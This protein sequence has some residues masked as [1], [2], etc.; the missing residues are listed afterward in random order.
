MKT[1]LIIGG[2][3]AGCAAGHIL[4]LQG[5]WNIDLVERNSFL[6]AGVHTF[7]RG[8]H[9]YTFGPRH[10]LTQNEETYHYLNKYCPLRDCSEHILLTYIEQDMAFYNFPMHKDD[11]L[12]MPDRDIIYREL[13]KAELSKKKISF[14]PSGTVTA[15]GGQFFATNLE[16]FWISS[17]GPT[18][19]GKFVDEYN[20]KMW[21]VED[22]KS[23][24]DFGWSPKGVALKEGPKE[25]WDDCISAYPIAPDGYN[26]YFEIATEN[27]NVIL[28]TTI[29][30]YDI[31][32]KTVVINSEKKVYDVIIN[33]IS[34][35]EIMDS[36]H[37]ELLFIGRDLEYFVLPVKET[38]PEN[39]YFLYYAGEE[40]YTRIVEYKKLTRQN[41]D[42]PTTLLSIEYPSKNGK[43]YPVPIKTE[44]AK[45]K[46]YF[47][48]MPGGVF[49]I[50]RAGSYDY[51][52]DIDDCIEQVLEIGKLLKS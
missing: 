52:I 41:L 22:N 20:K 46:K 10:F 42:H 30:K 19:Y 2:G 4:S 34:P 7:R 40:S 27:V 16:D 44:I 13:E 25:V 14:S 24:D 32:D 38:F 35:D 17:V 33:T 18:L 43:H 29:E 51:G 23:I 21:L 8:G 1:V 6:G 31:P 49:S 28:D 9:P 36:V 45:A 3:F 11:I 48:D 50:G 15:G 26:Q 37:G 47:D 12:K 5:G 39:V